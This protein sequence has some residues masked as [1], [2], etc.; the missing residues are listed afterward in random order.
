MSA[1]YESRGKRWTYESRWNQAVQS[2][3]VAL[4]VSITHLP[5][6]SYYVLSPPAR[7]N[8]TANS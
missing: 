2:M 6:A 7:I 8:A 1:F 3:W 5:Y 4:N